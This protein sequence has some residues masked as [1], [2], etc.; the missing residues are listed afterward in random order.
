MAALALAVTLGVLTARE[1][2]IGR[3]ALGA[4]EVAAAR[5]DWPEA[6]A[7]ARTA[8]EALAP[9]SPWPDR[10]LRRLEAIG[11]DAE[12]RGDDPTALLAYGAMRTAVLETRAAVGSM[13]AASRTER[14]RR[15][16]EDGLGRVAASSKDA[17]R[18]RAAS[19]VASLHDE[20]APAAWKLTALA[21][22]ALATL[23]GL[24][25]L[26]LLAFGGASWRAERAARAVALVGFVVY[27]TVAWMG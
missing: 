7:Q 14:W 16:A 15:T 5:S 19:V 2:P 17:P 18:A 12:A 13:G 23:G 25:A 9:G 26:A 10:G 21:A 11:H 4:A 8:A 22:S 6:V 1:F 24:T 20:R 3:E 27:A